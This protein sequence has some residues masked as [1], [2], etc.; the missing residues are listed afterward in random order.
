VADETTVVVQEKN[1][2]CV[3]GNDNKIINGEN[4]KE[5]KL[6]EYQEVMDTWRKKH[7]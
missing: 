3:G 5:Q 7:L 1:A 4:G 2:G 6:Q